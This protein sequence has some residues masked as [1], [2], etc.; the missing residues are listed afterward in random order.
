MNEDKL[1]RLAG[2]K[3][4]PPGILQKDYALTNLLSIVAKFSKLNSMILN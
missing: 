1:K 3:R 4:I 2:K